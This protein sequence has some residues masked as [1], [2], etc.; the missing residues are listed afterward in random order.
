MKRFLLSKWTVLGI[1]LLI[2]VLWAINV[3]DWHQLWVISW[4]RSLRGWAYG[5]R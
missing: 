3:Q 1:C 5:R 4:C 2:V